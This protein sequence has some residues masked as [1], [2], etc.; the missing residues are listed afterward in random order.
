MNYYG[1]IT[2]LRYFRIVCEYGTITKAAESLRVSQPSLT[3]AIKELEKELGISLFHRSKNNLSL[4]KQG[5]HVLEKTIKM[6]D[7]LDEYYTEI[8][9][10]GDLADHEVIIGLPIVFGAIIIPNMFKNVEEECK[11]ID[12]RMREC[13]TSEAFSLIDNNLI[14]IAV[15]ISNNVPKEYNSKILYETEFHYWVNKSHPLAKKKIITAKD[16]S[17][18]PLAMPVSESYHHAAITERFKDEGII[19]N[20][21]LD[22]KQLMTILQVIKNT[23]AGTITYKDM[24]TA[25]DTY[26]SIPFD[27]PIEARMIIVWKK[28][29]YITE[30]QKTVIKFLTNLV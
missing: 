7:S 23:D 14:N 28:D 21:K 4:T 26:A 5:K 3:V 25:P 16:I 24:P 19:P 12:V 1:N 6:L 15:L 20:I 11:G 29:N 8:L 13:T 27:P 17:A 22:S 2:R 30:A 18:Y 9:E 10:Y